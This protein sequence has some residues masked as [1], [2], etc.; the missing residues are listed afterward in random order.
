[1]PDDATVS[2]AMLSMLAS[3]DDA[4]GVHPMVADILAN[5]LNTE[6]E[7]QSSNGND[8]MAQMMTP[9]ITLPTVQITTEVEEEE[10]EEVEVE[11]EIEEDIS[12]GHNNSNNNHHGEDDDDDDEIEEELVMVDPVE[13]HLYDDSAFNQTMADHISRFLDED[14]AQRHASDADLVIPQQVQED[15]WTALYAQEDAEEA[16]KREVERQA[17]DTLDTLQVPQERSS[18][19][20]SMTAELSAADRSASR[21]SQRTATSLWD[22]ENNSRATSPAMVDDEV[23]E[24]VEEEK[25]EE[26]GS[27]E[28]MTTM[29]A[30]ATTAAA[31][32]AV[33]VDVTR[34][35]LVKGLIGDHIDETVIRDTFEKVGRDCDIGEHAWTATRIQIQRNFAPNPKELRCMVEFATEEEVNEVAKAKFELI[36]GQKG[37]LSRMTDMGARVTVTRAHPTNTTTVVIFTISSP[38]QNLRR[39][40]LLFFSSSSYYYLR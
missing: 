29:T 32:D 10:E 15:M 39:L 8:L 12:G 18:S 7:H 5:A 25:E 20:V 22:S 2:A 36:A 4:A 11:E 3:A 17:A 27:S 1:M 37:A 14:D 40:V 38:I 16:A 35:I 30:T 33:T 26:K 28:E 13:Q 31:N 21:G 19:R 34:S 6:E 9:T 24:E 23:E